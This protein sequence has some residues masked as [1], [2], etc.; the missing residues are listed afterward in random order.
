M[1]QGYCDWNILTSEH[2]CQYQFS[3]L[4]NCVF[5]CVKIK[6]QI[7]YLCHLVINIVVIWVITHFSLNWN[8]CIYMLVEYF[9]GPPANQKPWEKIAKAPD[10][11]KTD[12]M[13]C[14]AAKWA[15]M[16]LHP[17]PLKQI[18]LQTFIEKT[19]MVTSWRILS[20]KLI[21]KSTVVVYQVVYQV[22]I[23][24]NFRICG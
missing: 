23:V 16:N 12:P 3:F 8:L 15:P 17:R 7:S 21:I 9:G 14:V 18:C 20:A 19:D 11:A 10:K 1:K 5:I 4:I 22:V 6:V 13:A 24:V 2:Q